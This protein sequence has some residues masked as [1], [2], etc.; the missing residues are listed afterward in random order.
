MIINIYYMNIIEKVQNISNLF[1]CTLTTINLYYYYYVD[2]KY[3]TYSIPF[4][5]THF[6]I[7]L[8]FCK[9]DIKIH[10]LLGIMIIL[11]K[12]NYNIPEDDYKFIILTLYKT[13]IS[14]FFYVFRLYLKNSNI[15]KNIILLNDILFFL[16]FLK[17]RIIDYYINIIINPTTYLILN[18]YHSSCIFF[19]LYGIFLLNLYWVM[20]I[21]KIIYKSII[22]HK[23][24]LYTF[25]INI[26]TVAYIYSFAPNQSK[27]FDIA[28]I[29]ILAYNS[30]LYEISYDK[31]LSLY[32]NYKTS[33]NIRFLLC[34][35]T[36]LYYNNYHLILFS[37]FNHLY[38][39][40]NKTIFSLSY[41]IAFDIMLIIYF[42]DNLIKQINLII[43]TILLTMIFKMN[44]CNHIIFCI[45]IMMHTIF[46]ALCNLE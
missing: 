23:I 7:D 36:K 4:I 42:T 18:N 13:E 37:L 28:G 34:L 24:L 27:I 17:F 30:Y 38:G 1:I 15:S 16:I 8:F 6:C 19:P 35:V 3:L 44:L 41:P 11:F 43:I 12:Y 20:I 46:M 22:T 21:F 32:L 31:N 9:K 39:H 45:G 29:V 40:Y 25:I 10:H 33:I 14:T 26:F 5:F 2:T